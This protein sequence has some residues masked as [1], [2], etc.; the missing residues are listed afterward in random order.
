MGSPGNGVV[1]NR[2]S[3]KSRD[4]YV[5]HCNNLPVSPRLLAAS[6]PLAFVPIQTY[7]PPQAAFGFRRAD[8]CGTLLLR[9]G[10]TLMS[11]P[12]RNFDTKSHYPYCYGSRPNNRLESIANAHTAADLHVR[13]VSKT[14]LVSRSWAL[15]AVK[16]IHDGLFLAIY[17]IGSRSRVFA[18]VAMLQLCVLKAS[19]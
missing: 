11:R 9:A 7:Q 8:L 2:P 3:V 10:E 5:Q 17:L 16:Q 14:A 18:T 13:P 4:L 1:R 12:E 15:R 19:F 6:C